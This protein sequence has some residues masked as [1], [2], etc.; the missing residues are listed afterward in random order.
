MADLKAIPPAR[1]APQA[2]YVMHDLNRD[3]RQVEGQRQPQPFIPPQQDTVVPMVK[4]IAEQDRGAATA[5]LTKASTDLEQLCLDF[6]HEA[7]GELAV[8]VRFFR[9][10]AAR[11]TARQTAQDLGRTEEPDAVDLAQHPSQADVDR[12]VQL[13]ADLQWVASELAKIKKLPMELGIRINDI[14]KAISPESEPP[15]AA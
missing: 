4:P 5:R 6:T 12:M 14:V 8:V 9:S 3:T 2:G 13:T 15:K 1:I 7:Q 11:R 10:L